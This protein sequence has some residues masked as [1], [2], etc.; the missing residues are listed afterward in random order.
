MSP[1]RSLAPAP[2]I[3]SW[4]FDL[5]GTVPNED[6]EAIRKHVEAAGD[7][8]LTPDSVKEIATKSSLI[9]EDQVY[10]VLLQLD[11]LYQFTLENVVPAEQESFVRALL[12]ERFRDKPWLDILIQRVLLLLNEKPNAELRYQNAFLEKGVIPF[13]HRLNYIIDVRPTVSKDGTKILDKVVSAMFQVIVIDESK[14]E[15]SLVFQLNE[16]TLVHFQR[17]ISSALK[18]F[19]LFKKL[20]LKA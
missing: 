1:P 13:V 6:F 12:S 20:E 4:A 11:Q 19:S 9:K 5:V 15:K 18:K 16:E 7:F 8:N 10:R 3:I 17:Q 14:G 2:S